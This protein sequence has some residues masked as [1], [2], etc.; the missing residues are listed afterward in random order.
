MEI[1]SAMMLVFLATL[2]VPLGLAYI[3]F[4]LSSYVGAVVGFCIGFF[5]MF[6]LPS[7]RV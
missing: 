1:L 5:L 6:I 3:G 4:R 2:V 7:L